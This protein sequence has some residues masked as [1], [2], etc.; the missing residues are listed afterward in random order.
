MSRGGKTIETESRLVIDH[1]WGLVGLVACGGGMEKE[2]G[3]GISFREYKNVLKSE[4]GGA[5]QL[6]AYTEKLNCAL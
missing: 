6:Y 5:A 2:S 1:S 4:C 3:Q